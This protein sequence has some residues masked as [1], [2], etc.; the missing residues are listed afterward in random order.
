MTNDKE[1]MMLETVHNGGEWNLL[2]LNLYKCTCCEDQMWELEM[3]NFT[4]DDKEEEVVFSTEQMAKGTNWDFGYK[5]AD[6]YVNKYDP[7][8]YTI[9]DFADPEL[10]EF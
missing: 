9:E 1:K 8:D 6:N 3:I 2:S 7:D 4:L 10:A 5:I